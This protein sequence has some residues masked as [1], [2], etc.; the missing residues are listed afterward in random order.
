MLLHN[1]CTQN[2]WLVQLKQTQ[3]HPP[4]QEA[5]HTLPEPSS[6]SGG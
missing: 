1:D 2:L 3:S 4:H 5:D 6:S